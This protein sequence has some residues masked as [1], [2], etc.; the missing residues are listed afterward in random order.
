MCL[1]LLMQKIKIMNLLNYACLNIAFWLVTMKQQV[2]AV[3]LLCQV[4]REQHILLWCSFVWHVYWFAN[5]PIRK[6]LNFEPIQIGIWYILAKILHSDWSI[7]F[8]L[9]QSLTRLYCI[10]ALISEATIL[11]N[12]LDFKLDFHM[13]QWMLEFNFESKV[14]CVVTTR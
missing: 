5:I 9:F 1:N 10:P 3:F 8:N 6:R 13:L 2:C 12:W 7:W 14:K 4:P 11:L